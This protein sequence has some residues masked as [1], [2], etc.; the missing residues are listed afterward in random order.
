[1]KTSIEI[2]DVY[3]P[4]ASSFAK[5]LSRLNNVRGVVGDQKI[6]GKSIIKII[7]DGFEQE[8]IGKEMM[9]LASVDRHI[10]NK[11][12][13]EFISMF[14][15]D[16]SLVHVRDFTR[17]TT[18]S[19]AEDKALKRYIKIIDHSIDAFVGNDNNIIAL[20][21]KLA[22]IE[23]SKK[24]KYILTG[25]TTAAL[26]GIAAGSAGWDAATR[27]LIDTETDRIV[28]N[29]ATFSIA[30]D[31]A[32]SLDGG[33]GLITLGEIIVTNYGMTSVGDKL[34][35]VGY[36]AV[37]NTNNNIAVKELNDMVLFL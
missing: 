10:G 26:A 22:K 23:M 24:A 16:M 3:E 37:S 14:D 13:D 28:A 36:N 20:I 1:M 15:H 25:A 27:E 18:L 35:A 34:K 2:L 4:Q 12:S 30:I 21:R 9:D 19:D 6:R 7:K 31:R 29:N 17:L 32:M 33:N 5:L 8:P 11:F